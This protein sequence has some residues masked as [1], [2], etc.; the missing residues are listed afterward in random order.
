M[1]LDDT[2]QYW[3]AERNDVNCQNYWWRNLFYIQ[4]M[5]P[6]NDM[7]MSW[8]WFLAADFQCFCL[9][10][11]LLVIYT[12]YVLLRDGRRYDDM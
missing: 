7:C 5:Y 12:M 10:S 4:N 11:F 8:S 1:F 9:T 2:T 3:M 6:F